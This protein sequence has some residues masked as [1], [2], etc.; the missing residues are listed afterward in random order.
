M[1]PLMIERD[2]PLSVSFD[3]EAN[4]TYIRLA[5]EPSTGWRHGKTVPVLVDES[6][7]MVDVDVDVD[8]GRIMG[9]EILPARSLL[10]DK[11]L[12][13]LGL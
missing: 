12:H 11:I 3:A 7:G 4:A 9:F 10:S 5:D 2:V 13:A 6:N 8:D 1:I